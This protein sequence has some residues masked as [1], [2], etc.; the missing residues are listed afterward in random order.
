ML[1]LWTDLR[2]LPVSTC[3]GGHPLRT[4][5]RGPGPFQKKKTLAPNPSMVSDDILCWRSLMSAILAFNLSLPTPPKN[6][7]WKKSLS[8]SQPP[9]YTTETSRLQ[10][11]Q[12]NQRDELWDFKST[13]SSTYGTWDSPCGTYVNGLSLSSRIPVPDNWYTVATTGNQSPH[14]LLVRETPVP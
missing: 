5:G 7:L 2:L 3:W 8:L 11:Q 1:T 9:V 6:L 12:G 4:N 10:R 14:V 13:E